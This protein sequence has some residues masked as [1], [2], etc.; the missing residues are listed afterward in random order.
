[1]KRTCLVIRIAGVSGIKPVGLIGRDG[2]I[3]IAADQDIAGPLV[4]NNACAPNRENGWPLTYGRP[5][6]SLAS[7]GVLD[8]GTR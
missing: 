4:M 5:T 2:V 6:L 7:G 1:M 3:P 8:G